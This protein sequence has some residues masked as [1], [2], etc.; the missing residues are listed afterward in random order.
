MALSAKQQEEVEYLKR[1]AASLGY[2]LVRNR[3]VKVNHPVFSNY[4]KAW[5]DEDLDYITQALASNVPLKAMVDKVGR[6]PGAILG[7]L[8]S[9]GKLLYDQDSRG[10][11]LMKRRGALSE[12]YISYRDLKEL[13]KK[14]E[15]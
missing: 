15:H 3:N 13:E 4:G 6:T 7:R 1:R 8:S 12:V 9:L 11:I 2:R 5:T 14:Y 10:Y